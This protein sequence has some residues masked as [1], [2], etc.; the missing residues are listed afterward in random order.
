MKRSKNRTK[1]DEGGREEEGGSFS[2]PTSQHKTSLSSLEYQQSL[3]QQ[4]IENLS[5]Y[6]FK[7]K[8]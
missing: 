8:L 7:T 2:R 3:R 6:I 1:G 5:L 4:E